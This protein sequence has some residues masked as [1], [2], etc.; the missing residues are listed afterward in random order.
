MPYDI[1][2]A[3]FMHLDALATVAEGRPLPA[4][5]ADA[6]VGVGDLVAK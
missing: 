1:K 3:Y 6:E 5:D 4:D 2:Y